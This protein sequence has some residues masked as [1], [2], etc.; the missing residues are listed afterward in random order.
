MN[1]KGVNRKLSCIFS[2]DVVGYSRLM[3]KDEATT[4]RY[5]E[6]CKKLI[7]KLIEEYNGRVVDSPGDNLLAEFGSAVKAVECAVEVQEQLKGKNDQLEENKR[8]Q[9]RIGINVGDVI[10]ED[11]RLYGSG[12]NI[13]ARL[14][15]LARPGEIYVSR[16]VFDQVKISVCLGYEYLGEYNVKNLSEPVRVYRILTGEEFAG[17]IIGDKKIL[18]RIAYKICCS[19][20]LKEHKRIVAISAVIILFLMIGTGISFRSWYLSRLPSNPILAVLPFETNNLTDDYYKTFAIGFRTYMNDQLRKFIVLN[21]IDSNPPIK[22]REE[23]IITLQKPKSE[24]ASNLVMN[25]NMEQ[26]GEQLSISY[27]IINAKTKRKLRNDSITDSMSNTIDLM[28][29]VL[30]S[31]LSKLEV[32]LYPKEQNSIITPSTQKS[33]AFNNY[34]VAVGYLQDYHNS[35]DVQDAIRILEHTTM[36][37]DKEYAEAYATLGEALSRQYKEEKETKKIE[38]AL[39][40]CKRSM[41]LGSNLMNG[42]VCLGSVFNVKE[43][44]DKAVEEF[45]SALDIDPMSDEAC[46]GLAFAYAN[47]EMFDEAEEFYKRS[48]D[49]KPECWSG[50]NDLGS[51]YMKQARYSEA[52]EQFFQVTELVPDHHFGYSNLGGAYLYEGLYS[53]AIWACQLSVNLRLTDEAFSNMGTAHFC[54]DDFSKA[55]TSYEN[56]IKQN[57][58]FWMLWGNLGDARYW[59][60]TNLDYAMDAYQKA[61]ILAEPF[62]QKNPHNE[63]LQSFMAYYYAMLGEKEKAQNIMKPIVAMDSQ[64][65]EV[66]FNLAQTCCQLGYI[67]QTLDLLKKALTAGLSFKMIQ[68][69]PHFDNLDL[70]NNQEFKDLLQDY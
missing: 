15:S 25:V 58:E 51:M 35:E 17:E 24:E 16:N 49:L 50:H 61:L 34:L 68:T 7:S 44:Y 39:S 36:V 27:E 11:G 62:L 12:V 70:E 46:R 55:A 43:E 33:E 1:Q 19:L 66:L 22:I 6:E 48:I 23:N 53:R 64:N 20:G 18:G 26:V 52:A 40:S 63:I 2:T 10:E 45:L 38:E 5:L 69:N 37:D 28:N 65:P 47:L 4:I 9:F 59:E 21:S 42:Y 54:L 8:M 41:D 60:G 57:E 30:A 32:D 31:L 13:A 14:E 56:A 29:R 3:E 67:D